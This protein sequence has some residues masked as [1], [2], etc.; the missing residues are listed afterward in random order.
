M[1]GSSRRSPALLLR[2]VVVRDCNAAVARTQNKN[3]WGE[4]DDNYNDHMFQISRISHMFNLA[5]LQFTLCI[6]L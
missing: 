3:W 1:D 6:L 4:K 2:R 5:S